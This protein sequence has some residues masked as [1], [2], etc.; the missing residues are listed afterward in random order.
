MNPEMVCI[1]FSAM[2]T[3]V[4]FKKFI[5]SRSNKK[6]LKKKLYEGKA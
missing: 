1:L 6:N 2:K 3:E 4:A 5:S